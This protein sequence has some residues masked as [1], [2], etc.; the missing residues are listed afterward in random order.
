MGQAHLLFTLSLLHFFLHNTPLLRSF[1]F[2]P[3]T[4]ANPPIIVA[5][6]LSQLVLSPLDAVFA[7]AVNV[8]TRKFEYEADRFAAEVGG[9]K[10]AEQ[11][12]I[13]LR[14]LHVSNA[15]TIHHDWLC[16]LSLPCSPAVPLLRTH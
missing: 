1:R 15:S 14:R 9:P 7:L 16:V 12:K 10:M 2:P 13:A 4:A 5:F 11:L 3:A 8:V 6:L